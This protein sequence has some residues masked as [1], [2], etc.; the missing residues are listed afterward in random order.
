MFGFFK[1]KGNQDNGKT[2]QLEAKSQPAPKSPWG[3]AAA[4][5]DRGET[6]QAMDHFARTAVQTR[7]LS[8]MDIA[9][10]W[11]SDQTILD[12]AGEAVICRFVAILTQVLDPMEPNQRE[13]MW[14]LCLKVLR[15]LGDNTE[16]RPDTTNRYTA[17]CILLRH[18]GRTEEALKA[19]QEGISRHKAASCYT[20]AGLCC[21]D[22]G[23]TPGAENHVREGLE[24]DPQNLA[25]C[26]DL[27]DFFLDHNNLPKAIEYYTMVVDRGDPPDVEWAEPSLIFCRWL[28]S[29][30]PVELERLVLCAASKPQN[31]RGVQLC[32]AARQTRA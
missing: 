1:K 23:D 13:R 25:P 12:R 30:D 3:E 26:N 32:Q 14:N 6:T 5:M 10:R 22:L 4:L 21:L 19:A 8:H 17:E 2:N 29:R 31:Q 11:L 27:A 9:E 15:N 28:E 16:P 20:F 7:D 18:M 24:R